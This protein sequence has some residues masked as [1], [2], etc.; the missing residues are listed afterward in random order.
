METPRTTP[1]TSLALCYTSP[2]RT[3]PYRRTPRQRRLAG[4]KLSTSPVSSGRLRRSPVTQNVE[5]PGALPGLT[6]KTWQV[7]YLSPLYKFSTQPQALKQYGRS[8]A[9]FLVQ[10]AD[11][12]IAVDNGCTKQCVFS[13]YEGLRVNAADP[14]AI[15]I[16]VTTKATNGN[17][18]TNGGQVLLTAVLCGIDLES[19]PCTGLKKHFTYYPILLVKSRVTLSALL[20]SWLQRHFDCRISPL[21]PTSMD[22]AWMVAMWSGTL[23]ERKNKPVELLYSVPEECEGLS[24]ITYTINAEDCKTLWDSIRSKGSDDFTGE[25]V[26]A[27]VKSLEEHFYECFKVKLWKMELRRVGTPLAYIGD[28]KVKIFSPE[29]A[30]QVL[31]LLSEL[32]LEQFQLLATT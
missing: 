5:K 15:Q 17:K 2:R 26:G 13:V 8:L 11:K 7:L 23:A 6:N 30:W 12:E 3:C 28:G 24:R 29:N 31:R 19:N 20:K 1:S 21:M 10:E 4:P 16:L 27:F 18:K 14:E 9:T 22:L 25:E 32:A